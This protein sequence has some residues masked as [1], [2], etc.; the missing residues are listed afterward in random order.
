M[1]IKVKIPSC[2]N[3]EVVQT[4][5]QPGHGQKIKAHGQATKQAGCSHTTCMQAGIKTTIDLDQY[6]KASINQTPITASLRSISFYLTVVLLQIF[7][8]YPNFIFFSC[9]TN[10]LY[11]LYHCII[12]TSFL[13]KW[14]N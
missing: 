7:Q 13:N 4:Y 9:G 6:K 8:L 2:D 3:H 12:F 11:S 14:N 1:A 5:R 10:Q